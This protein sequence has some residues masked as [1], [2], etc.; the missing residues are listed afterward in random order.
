MRVILYLLFAVGAIL[1]IFGNSYGLVLMAPVVID[2]VIND[3][4]KEQD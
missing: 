3:N 4:I 1:T 2:D